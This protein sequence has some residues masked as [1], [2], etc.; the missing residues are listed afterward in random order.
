MKK[1]PGNILTHILLCDRVCPAIVTK[2]LIGQINYPVT[3]Y[4]THLGK[5]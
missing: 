2:H 1:L 4:V 3:L 5:N